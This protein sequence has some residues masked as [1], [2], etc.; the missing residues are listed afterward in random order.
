MAYKTKLAFFIKAC[1]RDIDCFKQLIKSIKKFNKD[2]IPICISVARSEYDVFQNCLKNLEVKCNIF[3]DEDIIEKYIFSSDKFTQMWTY[4]QLV[5]LH[6][7]K[8]EFAE[9]YILIDCDGYFIQDFYKSDFLYDNKPC[10]P[11]TGHT[12]AERLPM[13][14]LYKESEKYNSFNIRSTTAIKDFFEKSYPTLTIDMPFILTSDYV[15]MLEEYC[16][17]KGKTFLDLLKISPFEMQ[18]YVDFILSF[19]LPYQQ[20]TAYFM[21][22]HI[23]AQYQIFRLLGFDEKDF[24]P[25]YLGILL[26]KGHVND[27]TYKPSFIG[28]H[29]VRPLLRRYYNITKGRYDL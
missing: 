18:W 23:H 12:K 1:V 6:F 13:S 28:K 27:I 20:T 15:K 3:I 8:T 10:L 7:Y 14:I 11:I 16:V 25:N 26:N 17:Q 29:I 22:F 2:D 19:N 21:P 4:Q 5:K 9:H 24:I